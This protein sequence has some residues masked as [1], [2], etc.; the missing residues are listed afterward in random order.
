MVLEANR[1]KS[2]AAPE[3]QDVPKEEAARKTIGAL[4][5][6]NGKTDP[7]RWWVPEEFGRRPAR[8]RLTRYAIPA[9]RKGHGRQGP[10]EDIVVQGTRKGRT[11]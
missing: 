6:R 1:E 3:L 9:R 11:L 7:G 8:R 2:E 4:E 5:G 10:G